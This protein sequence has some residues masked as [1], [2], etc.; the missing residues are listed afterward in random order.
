[1]IWIIA[2]IFAIWGIIL[3][4]AK[5][6]G[7]KYGF[8]LAGPLLMWK[9]E[10]GKKFI[11]R[12]AEKRIWGKY[13]NFSIMVCII[14]MIF[15][16]W[17]ILWNVLIAIKIPPQN[18]PS[19]RLILG[20]PGINPIIP[21]GYGILALAI[22]IVIHEFSHGIMAKF[23]KIKINYLGL[24]FLIVP[25]GAFV[26]PDEE[27]LKKVSVLKRSRVFAS[28]PSSNIILAIICILLLSF[29]FSPLITPKTEGVI[30]TQD[31]YG[32]D[33][34]SVITEVEGIKV[35]EKEKFLNVSE[36]FT[37]GEFYN[38]TVFEKNNLSEKRILYGVVVLKI[39]KDSPAENKLYE[40]CI[41]Y[42]I[43]NH[44]IGNREDFFS[45][46]N[47]TT[48]GEK[49]DIYFYYNNS[50][51]NTSVI[52]AD[53][54]NFIKN[55]KNIGKGFLGVEAYSIDN[56][57]LNDEYIKNVFNPLKTELNLNSI[58]NK[59]LSFIALPF[60]G[61]SPPPQEIID[62]YTPSEFFWILYNIV[63]WI[64]WLNFAVGTFNA[65]PSMP[66][67]GGYIFR[68]GINYILSKF[69]SAKKERVE[70]ISSF[71]SSAVSIIVFI[72]IFS[73]ILIPRLRF[74]I[75]S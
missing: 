50:K 14:A 32:I 21:I 33:K 66:L 47:S 6:K 61:L 75:S 39:V 28:G 70:K 63:Y 54:Y 49:I 31:A 26:E 44:S 13:G 5:I 35:N 4:I 67:D 69:S 53:K 65:L 11:E 59:F 22:A 55:D 45:F 40:K 42:R 72:G 2:L 23:G 20:I 46:M 37:A 41:I 18:A 19:P 16:T 57:L 1:M 7:K 36:N 56:L 60:T 8:D 71:L 74:L 17:L 10:K 52:L 38:I 29:V 9:T 58:R 27:K 3:Y 25:V 64:F 73:I 43:N 68:D 24:L 34:W 12:I 30:I 48:A 15:T 62:I 51:L